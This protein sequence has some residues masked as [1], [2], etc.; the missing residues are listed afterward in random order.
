MRDIFSVMSM[1]N[2]IKD[3]M[4]Y[5]TY[6]TKIKIRSKWNPFYWLM[7][8]QKVIYIPYKKVIQCKEK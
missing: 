6:Y 7:R 3:V 8:P 5:G 4:I 2:A 1:E